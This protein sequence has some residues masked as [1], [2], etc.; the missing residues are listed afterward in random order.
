MISSEE[1]RTERAKAD[2]TQPVN[3]AATPSDARSEPRA[4]DDGLFERVVVEVA[5][6]VQHARI[7]MNVHADRAR[8]ELRRAL[9]R[10]QRE[11]VI[12]VALGALTVCGLVLLASGLAESLSVAFGDRPWL[13]KLGA[14]ALLLGVA[15]AVLAVRS[16]RSERAHLEK[17]RAKY[18]RLDPN[19][20]ADAPRSDASA[21]GGGTPRAG[22]GPGPNRPAAQPADARD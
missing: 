9:Q 5:E 18:E 17:L 10:A 14:A 12:L 8:L 22:A 6:A 3:G 20:C 21:H 1:E 11:F 19:L 16:A 13:G 4:T 7:L 15:A 2:E